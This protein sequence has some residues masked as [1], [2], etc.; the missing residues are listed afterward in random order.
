MNRKLLL[1]TTLGTF[2]AINQGCSDSTTSEPMP[3]AAVMPDPAQLALV[4][5]VPQIPILQGTTA[6]FD[7]TLICGPNV[8]GAVEVE[9][10]GLP[11][12]VTFDPLTI[13]A[14]ATTGTLTLHADAAAAHS[15]PTTVTIRATTGTLVASNEV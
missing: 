15:L 1:S 10:V 8:D 5:S 6:S 4:T 2:L 9:P 11:P 12:G 14:G 3:D 13:A 7:I